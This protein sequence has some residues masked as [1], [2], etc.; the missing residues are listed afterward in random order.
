MGSTQFGNFHVS[1]ASCDLQPG[2]LCAPPPAQSAAWSGPIPNGN[3]NRHSA[4]MGKRAQR[5]TQRNG[6]R[7]ATDRGRYHRTFF[8]TRH[9]PFA[10]FVRP[11]FFPDSSYPYL[12]CICA[13][14]PPKLTVHSLLSLAFQSQP[15]A[16]T[17]LWWMYFGRYQPERRSI[18]R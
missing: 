6:T 15:T 17:S 12:T 13:C 18:P 14:A 8:A 1:R 4:T 3:K 2:M 16:G 5:C 7:S 11:F 9:Y 10:M